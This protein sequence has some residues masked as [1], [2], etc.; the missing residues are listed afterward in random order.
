MNDNET[1]AIVKTESFDDVVER[2]ANNMFVGLKM[3]FDQ[4]RM[5]KAAVPRLQELLKA[6]GL[7]TQPTE[8]ETIETMKNQIVDGYRVK[9]LQILAERAA[10][11]EFSRLYPDLFP[12]TAAADPQ[13]T[14]PPAP[15][16]D[17]SN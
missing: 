10:Q 11:E 16:E 12:S 6:A 3:Q 14:P 2:E 5:R 17:P 4:E 8:A 1:T 7:P 15:P 13:G 9:R